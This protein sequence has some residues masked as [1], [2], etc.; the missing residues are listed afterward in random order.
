MS[1][2]INALEDFYIM[3]EKPFDDEEGGHF[4]RFTNGIGIKA[5]VVL[6]SSSIR[7][8]GEKETV[9]PSFLIYSYRNTVLEHPMVIKCKRDGKTYRI[10]TV[11]NSTPEA[12][13]L[14]C[15]L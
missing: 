1:L 11:Q 14:I 2:V 10:N 3:N 4:S 12:A 13:A 15:L 6:N 9:V 7:L 5:A 8:Q